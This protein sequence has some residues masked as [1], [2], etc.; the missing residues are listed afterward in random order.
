MDALDLEPRGGRRLLVLRHRRP[1]HRGPDHAPPDPPGARPRSPPPPARAAT[2]RGGR[3][4]SRAGP[5]PAG[6]STR[7]SRAT[8]S[9]RTRVTR[10]PPSPS[11]ARRTASRTS[12]GPRQVHARGRGRERTRLEGGPGE[13]AGAAPAQPPPTP[14]PPSPRRRRTRGRAGY[15]GA[16][17][18]DGTARPRARIYAP[19]AGLYDLRFAPGGSANHEG[20]RRPEHPQRG[21]RGARRLREDLARLGP[22]LRRRRRQP[23]G[24]GGRRDDRHRLR[25]RRDRAQDQPP[26]RPRLRRVEEGQG[27]PPRRARATPTSSP[28]PAPPC[29]WRTPPSSWWTRWRGSRSRPRRCGATP[30]S[31]ASPRLIVV[32]RMDRENASFERALEK[33][34]ARLRP[35]RGAGRGPGGRGEGLQ[36]ASWTSCPGRPRS[37]ATTRAASSRSWTSPPPSRS[38]RRPGARSSSRWWR[39]ATRSSWR[40][41]SR[42]ARCPRSSS[43][44]GCASAVAAGRVFPVLPAS[45]LLNVGVH[46]APRRDRGPRSP[47]PR[48]AARSTGTRPRHEGGGD[49][50]A[51]GGRAALGL[52]VQD[53]RRP[54][55]RAHQPLPRL[56]RA[57]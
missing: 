4:R 56:L 6:S 33:V 47:R 8:P 45:A 43:R 17:P 7:A 20:V 18:P 26:R 16:P 25:P 9:G 37:T 55:R 28:R 38:R 46:A 34:Q 32:N 19:P 3:A 10:R 48:T 12:S 57:R 41:S 1:A 22:A 15:R 49:P 50:Q 54:A 29:G 31:T 35:R 44:R 39:R 14:P 36:G 13:P 21:H 30:R 23:A 2:R 52:R 42:R 27:Q 40:S 51:R 53:D 5:R 24:T 11:R